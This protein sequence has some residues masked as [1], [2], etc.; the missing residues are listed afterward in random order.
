[1]P[2]PIAQMRPPMMS[3]AH[4]PVAA[5]PLFTQ[6]H[7]RTY[8]SRVQSCTALTF[9]FAYC[10]SIKV[11][12]EIHIPLFELQVRERVLGEQL[13]YTSSHKSIN[14]PSNAQT[15]HLAHT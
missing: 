8:P 10:S 14:S 15:L 11:F 3:D 13:K 7:I 6:I 1:M 2:R 4:K 12:V 5:A 9:N